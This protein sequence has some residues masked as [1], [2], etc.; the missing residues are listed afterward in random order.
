MDISIFGIQEEYF[1][2]SLNGSPSHNHITHSLKITY[3]VKVREDRVITIIVEDEVVV[4]ERNH[5]ILSKTKTGFQITAGD[6]SIIDSSPLAKG[7][8][9]LFAELTLVAI[10]HARTSLLYSA[11]QQD[12]IQGILIPYNSRQ[13]HEKLTKEGLQAN[14]N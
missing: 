3:D 4:P 9:E 1:S 10:A 7:S 8:F 2:D 13:E 6:Y 12:Q 14:M 11:M 5:V